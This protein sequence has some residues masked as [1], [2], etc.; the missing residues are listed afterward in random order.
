MSALKVPRFQ[1]PQ[2]FSTS[3]KTSSGVTSAF[4]MIRKAHH[5]SRAFS[6]AGIGSNLSQA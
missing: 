1:G 3:G 4:F 6:S 5:I 2:Y